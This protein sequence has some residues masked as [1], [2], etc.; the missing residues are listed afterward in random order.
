MRKKKGT[1]KDQVYQNVYD[2]I[3]AGYYSEEDIITEGSLIEKY[4]VSKSPVR[5]ALIQL[6]SENVLRSLP[7]LGYQVVTISHKDVLDIMEYRLL[8]ESFAIDKAIANASD[9]DFD[10]MLQLSEQAKNTTDIRESMLYNAQF[11]LYICKLS[12]NEHL[13]SMMEMTMKRCNRYSAQHILDSWK[14]KE[15]GI[16]SYHYEITQAMRKKD[17]DLA[18]EMLKKDLLPL[19]DD[20]KN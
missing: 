19:K 7:R 8:V 6:C 14:K 20:F 12:G 11:H 13:Y 4:Q 3:I 17:G 9:A 1:L 2:D 5:E 16:P 10:Y 18:K 15:E